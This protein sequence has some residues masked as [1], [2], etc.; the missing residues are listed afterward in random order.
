MT[1]AANWSL[2]RFIKEMFPV[3]GSS[4]TAGINH[5]EFGHVFTTVTGT[6]KT[7]ASPAAAAG[8]Q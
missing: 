3:P 4:G 1:G 5:K 7:A 6:E 2:N 8:I